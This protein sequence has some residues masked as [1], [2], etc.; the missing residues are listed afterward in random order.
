[1]KA[2]INRL[3]FILISIGGI[4]IGIRLCLPTE[5]IDVHRGRDLIVKNFPVLKYNREQW[6]D[7]N[8]PYLKSKYDFPKTKSNG[9]YSVTIFDIGHGYEEEIPERDWLLPGE[10]TD[11]LYCYNEMN[12]KNQCVRKDNM[13][14][15][16]YKNGEGKITFHSY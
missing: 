6:W 4:Y 5:I 2:K 7:K 11:H 3:F 16:I 14:M 10:T 12:V 1:M 13:L 8:E 9:S 15:N